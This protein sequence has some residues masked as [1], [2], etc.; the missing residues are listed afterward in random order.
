MAVNGH[1]LA[2]HHGT[3]VGPN[4]SPIDR[5]MVHQLYSG[6]TYDISQWVADMQ[7]WSDFPTA[8]Q[9]DAWYDPPYA[10]H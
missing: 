5:I 2:D 7:I 9:G 1:V 10:S 6:S 4:A 3:N 8:S